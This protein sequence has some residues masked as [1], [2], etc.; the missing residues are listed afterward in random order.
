MLGIACSKLAMV[1]RPRNLRRLR[2]ETHRFT[3]HL[4]YKAR[5]GCKTTVAGTRVNQSLCGWSSRERRDPS[6]FMKLLARDPLRT[7]FIAV[8]SYNVA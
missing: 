7:C 8:S 3:V 4:H 5:Q 6:M 2:Q 1:A